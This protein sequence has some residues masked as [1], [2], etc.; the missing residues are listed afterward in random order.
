[1]HICI[2]Y[3]DKNN[4]ILGVD[5]SELTIGGVQNLVLEL[6][7]HPRTE[8]FRNHKYVFQHK[9]DFCKISRS[10]ILTNAKCLPKLVTEGSLTSTKAL[11]INKKIFVDN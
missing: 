1:M 6:E 10:G 7:T 5:I 4:I 9:R 3:L 2:K 8:A 11:L